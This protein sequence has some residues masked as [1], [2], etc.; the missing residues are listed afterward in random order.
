[1]ARISFAN[2]TEYHDSVAALINSGVDAALP[3]AVKAALDGVITGIQEQH[4]KE[5]SA[6]NELLTKAREANSAVDYS[7]FEKYPDLISLMKAG[8]VR[9]QAMPGLLALQIWKGVTLA[10]EMSKNIGTTPKLGDKGGVPATV[11][12]VVGALQKLERALLAANTG[13]GIKLTSI[14]GKKGEDGDASVKRIKF[15]PMAEIAE[16]YAET[17]AAA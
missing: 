11:K 16:D 14:R 2:E 13:V 4:A 3:E 9:P 17:S 8:D 12:I 1:M 10:S 5:I 15:R 7:A 6:L